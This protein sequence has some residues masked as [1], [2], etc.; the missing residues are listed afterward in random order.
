MSTR[1][2]KQTRKRADRL[3]SL[4]ELH[5]VLVSRAFIDGCP[6]TC[7][8]LVGFIRALRNKKGEAEKGVGVCVC[9]CVCVCVT[10]QKGTE[11]L[12]DL[13]VYV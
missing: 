9:V 12:S 2:H 3:L 1:S 11:H 13:Y 10:W 6:R 8:A 7:Q 4:D 5:I